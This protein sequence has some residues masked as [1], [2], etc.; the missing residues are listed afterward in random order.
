MSQRRAV[1]SPV[2]VE[3]LGVGVGA[4][5]MV[6]VLVAAFLPPAEFL[7]HVPVVAFAAGPGLFGVATEGRTGRAA[8]VGAGGFL[9]VVF[10][11]SL[12][13]PPTVAGGLTMCLGAA[14]VLAGRPDRHPT[15]A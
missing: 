8:G 11:L 13:D 1:D 15:G 5:G 6:A 10:G 9:A 2:A 7:G 12:A 3:R 4:A 14:L